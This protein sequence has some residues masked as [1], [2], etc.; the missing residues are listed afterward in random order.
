VAVTARE[1]FGG[2]V[3]RVAALGGASAQGSEN[4][5]ATERH[6][7]A[8]SLVNESLNSMKTDVAAK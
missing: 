5:T 8:A 6:D 2:A 4:R 3:F 1:T 7:L